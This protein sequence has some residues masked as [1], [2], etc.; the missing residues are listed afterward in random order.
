MADSDNFFTLESNRE[1]SPIEAYED[2][3]LREPLLEV[4]DEEEIRE[5]PLP[6]HKHCLRTFLEERRII[7]FSPPATGKGSLLA[8]AIFQ[9]FDSRRRLP[10]VLI[11]ESRKYLVSEMYRT[12]QKW[13]KHFTPSI[14]QTT[15]ESNFA[16][17]LNT[18]KT[19]QIIVGTTGRILSMVNKRRDYFNMVEIVVIDAGGGLQRNNSYQESQRKSQYDEGPTPIEVLKRLHENVRT[20]WISCYR[21]QDFIEKICRQTRD[22]IIL[23]TA[24]TV[25][26]PEGM[27]HYKVSYRNPDE[28][29]QKLKTLLNRSPRVQKVIYCR[30]DETMMDLQSELE[31]KWSTFI[32]IHSMENKNLVQLLQEFKNKGFLICICASKRYIIRQ[33]DT[34]DPI[35]VYNFDMPKKHEKYIKRIRRNGF[36]K[37]DTIFSFVSSEEDR[38]MVSEIENSYSYRIDEFESNLN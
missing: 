22:P 36:L 33:I 31:E 21:D 10:Q 29:L 17:D 5:R 26:V 27:I 12:L 8:L 15:G 11:L 13:G 19:A 23:N 18:A 38:E 25:P 6:L 35:E 3:P 28:K 4:L 14:L 16:V 37:C 34:L 7:L 24:F 30:S 32:L 9:L 20:W 2:I 1:I